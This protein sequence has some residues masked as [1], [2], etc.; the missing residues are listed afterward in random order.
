PVAC[1]AACGREK[2]LPH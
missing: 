1:Y 2:P